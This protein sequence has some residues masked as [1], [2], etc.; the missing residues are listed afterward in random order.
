MVCPHIV[1]TFFAMIKCQERHMKID[2]LLGRAFF[3]ADANQANEAIAQAH[4]HFQRITN[5]DAHNIEVVAPPDLDIGWARD[6]LLQRLVYF[7]ESVGQPLPRCPQ[8]FLS[9]FYEDTVSF[10]AAAEV[11]SW[12]EQE[13]Q[14]SARELDE[15][16]GTHEL[17]TALR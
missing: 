16:Y 14:L 5:T 4:D 12:A 9:L 6:Q 11:I 2:T 13:L 17:D 10:V 8:V 3:V 1:G 15:L 7:C